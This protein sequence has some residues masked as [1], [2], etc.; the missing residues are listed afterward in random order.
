MAAD[1]VSPA[2]MKTAMGHSSLATTSVYLR[3]ERKLLVA[4][5]GKLKR[6]T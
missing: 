4:E 2:A 6:R 5:M 3:P 1:D